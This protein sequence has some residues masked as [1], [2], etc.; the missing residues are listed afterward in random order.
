[1]ESEEQEGNGKREW[2]TV[3]KRIMK[4][5]LVDPIIENLEIKITSSATQ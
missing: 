4:E 1:V 3:A 2:R 5:N